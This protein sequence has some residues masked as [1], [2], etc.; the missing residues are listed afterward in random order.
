MGAKILVY[1]DSIFISKSNNLKKV[2]ISTKP[3]PGFTDLQAQF[4]VLM[5]QANGY[6]KLKRIFLKIDLCTFQN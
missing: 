2:N 5:T 4:M 6:Q 3:F 1:K